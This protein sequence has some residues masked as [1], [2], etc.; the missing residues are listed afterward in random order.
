VTRRS[1]T[2]A[3]GAGNSSEAAALTALACVLNVLSDELRAP[4]RAGRIRARFAARDARGRFISAAAARAR[5]L[6][7]ARGRF[8]TAH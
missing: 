8:R 7:D 5:W 6:R 2:E 1:A 3:G 4:V